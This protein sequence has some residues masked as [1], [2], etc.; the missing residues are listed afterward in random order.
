MFNKKD[1]GI[2]YVMVGIILDSYKWG[3]KL[4][5]GLEG[6]IEEGWCEVEMVLKYVEAYDFVFEKEIKVF[7]VLLLLY[8]E[9]KGDIVWQAVNKVGFLFW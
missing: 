8:F 4:L 2:F 6:I 9:N 3:V 5:G 1:L 7:Y